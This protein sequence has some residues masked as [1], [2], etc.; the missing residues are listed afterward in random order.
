MKVTVLRIF[1]WQHNTFL[2]LSCSYPS[3]SFPQSFDKTEQNKLER[4]AGR[5][6]CV[7]VAY[8]IEP[9]IAERC[10]PDKL[11]LGGFKNGIR[12]ARVWHYRGSILMDLER[13]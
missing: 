4:R 1:K 12:P 13:K 7:I 9:P 11:H 3:A 6:I 10:N 8:Q 2:L 5:I